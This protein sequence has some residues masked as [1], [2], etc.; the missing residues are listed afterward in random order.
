MD[1]NIS[2][3]TKIASLSPS[4]KNKLQEEFWSVYGK[5]KQQDLEMVKALK[6]GFSSI[7]AEQDVQFLNT[8]L[9]WFTV[10]FWKYLNDQSEEDLL[11]FVPR[12]F[13]LAAYDGTRVKERLL[14]YMQVVL[15][16]PERVEPFYESL[17]EAQMSAESVIGT[18]HSAPYRVNELVAHVEKEQGKTKG[19]IMLWYTENV[20]IETIFD[21]NVYGGDRREA[22]EELIDTVSF[23]MLVPPAFIWHYVD[24]YERVEEQKYREEHDM[25]ISPLQVEK[26]FSTFE[27]NVADTDQT[28]EPALPK[29]ETSSLSQNLSSSESLR[30]LDNTTESLRNTLEW[31]KTFESPKLAWDA[32]RQRIKEEVTELDFDSANAVM[33]LTFFLKQNGYAS[34]PDIVYYDQGSNSFHWNQ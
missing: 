23:F 22:T 17:R 14:E 28:N 16:V 3:F 13:S 7:D 20:E 5:S 25:M 31:L 21:P 34:E 26:E 12:T 29:S 8:H 6:K 24:T 30:M 27:T 1:E 4:Q 9:Y 18:L 11:M 15:S 33:Q 32:L 10:L 2:Q 19:D